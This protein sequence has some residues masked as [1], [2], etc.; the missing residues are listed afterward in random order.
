M[1]NSATENTI[2]STNNAV[3]EVSETLVY[4][5][6]Y[7]YEDEPGSFWPSR[8]FTRKSEAQ[9]YMNKYNCEFKNM[10]Y[11]VIPMILEGK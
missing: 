4:L 3:V 10:F 5:V 7:E 1:T 11:S 8:I 2:C 9:K 6:Q